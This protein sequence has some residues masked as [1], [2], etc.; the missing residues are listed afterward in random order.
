MGLNCGLEVPPN[1]KYFLCIQLYEEVALLSCFGDPLPPW[2]NVLSHSRSTLEPPSPGTSWQQL[3][4]APSKLPPSTLRGPQPAAQGR[5]LRSLPPEGR[6]TPSSDL[7]V[8]WLPLRG[9]MPPLVLGPP[10]VIT[11]PQAHSWVFIFFLTLKSGRTQTL[12]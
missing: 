7:G 12:M 4:S 2:E 10:M 1:R 3:R 11:Q 8:L 9:P 6:D 5:V